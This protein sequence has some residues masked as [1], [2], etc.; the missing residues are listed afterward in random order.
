[1]YRRYAIAAESDLR[2]AG[3]KLTAALG[4]MPELGSLSQ[5]EFE[6]TASLLQEAL[7][8]DHTGAP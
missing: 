5:V 8:P 2:D 7:D 3:T 1:V 4:T 6:V